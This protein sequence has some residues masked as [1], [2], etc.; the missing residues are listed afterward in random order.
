MRRSSQKE[1]IHSNHPNTSSFFAQNISNNLFFSSNPKID[2]CFFQ[3][4]LFNIMYYITQRNWKK[5]LSL[6]TNNVLNKTFKLEGCFYEW[7]SIKEFGYR[8]TFY[9]WPWRIY[10]FHFFKFYLCRRTG[11]LI[12]TIKLK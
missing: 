4:I 10:L 3:K 2:D 12:F 7:S 11:F 6:S 1:I 9:K 8:N 5:K